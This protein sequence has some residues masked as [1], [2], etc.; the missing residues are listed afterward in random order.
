M[1]HE[2]RQQMED[3]KYTQVDK[4]VEEYCLEGRLEFPGCDLLFGRKREYSCR[5]N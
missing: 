2:I 1:Q 4:M 3:F 5:S